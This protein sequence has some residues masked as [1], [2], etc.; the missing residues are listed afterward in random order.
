MKKLLCLLL[1]ALMLLAVLAGCSTKASPDTSVNADPA[2]QAEGSSDKEDAASSEK[3]S[4]EFYFQKSDVEQLMQDIVSKFEAENPDIDISLTVLPDSETALV[5][6]IATND[7]P[8]IISIWPAEKFYRDLMRDGVLMDI[9]NQEFMNQVSDSAR[10]IAQ[11]DGKDYAYSLSMSA[12]GLIIN[13]DLFEQ[14]HISVPK[15]WDELIA[16]AAAFQDIGI[17]PFEF[18]DKSTEALA[19]QAE[20]MSGILNNDI[21][22]KITAVGKGETTW[23]NEP[24]MSKLADAMLEL[25]QYCQPDTL[26]TDSSQGMNDMATGKVAMIIDGGWRVAQILKINPDA[27]IEMVTL[28]NPDGKNAIPASIDCAL[29]ISESCPNKEAALKFLAFVAT[30]EIAQYYADNEKNPSVVKSVNYN[31]AEFEKI[32]EALNKG[33]FFFTPG[34]YWPAGFRNSWAPSVQNLI[35][36]QDKETF[37]KD[38]DAVCVEYFANAE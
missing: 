24:E 9:S 27:N 10:A 11:Y 12:Y 23:E 1:A 29:T 34:V 37:L 28:P 17:T 26:G 15:T 16:A 30:P 22:S 14:N 35:L 36:T 19:Q 4:L 33:D 21:T 18:Y 38:T 25:R 5:S 8:D 6:R 2:A 7:Y 31:V 13:K 32:A 3:I 20:R